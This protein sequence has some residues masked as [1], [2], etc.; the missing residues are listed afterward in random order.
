MKFSPRIAVALKVALSI[1]IA[2]QTAFL[3]MATA[4]LPGVRSV[5]IILG[6]GIAVDALALLIVFRA[7]RR[8]EVR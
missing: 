5:P 7:A 6:T 4:L 2:L 8:L 3:L 1:L